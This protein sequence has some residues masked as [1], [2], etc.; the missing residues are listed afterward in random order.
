MSRKSHDEIYPMNVKCAVETENSK[1][2]PWCI[3][4]SLNT[5]QRM[6]TNVQSLEFLSPFGYTD[7]DK[8]ISVCRI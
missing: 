4:R 1:T 7:N 6:Y 5:L 2:V 8:E 3:A